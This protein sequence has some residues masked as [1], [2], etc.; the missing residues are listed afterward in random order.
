MVELD[1][2]SSPS[3]SPRLRRR[4]KDPNVHIFRSGWLK[5]RLSLSERERIE[6]RDCCATVD[7]RCL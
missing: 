3:S 4:G 6:V 2:D 1:F 7:E 5:I